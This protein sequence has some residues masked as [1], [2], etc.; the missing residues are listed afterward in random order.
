MFNPV[1][2]GWINYYASFYKSALYPTL[3]HVDQVLARWAERKYK[4]LHGHLRRARHWLARV[5]APDPG[6]SLTGSSC[7]RGLDNGSCVSRE[8]HAQFCERVGVRLPRATLLVMLF[9]YKDDAERVLEVLGKRLG[10][11]G[12]GCPHPDKT[13]MVDFRYRPFP[14]HDREEATLATTFN[15]LGFTHVWGRSRK[16]KLVVRQVTAKDRFARTLKAIDQQCRRMRHWM[17]REPHQRLCQ[18]LRGHY[19]YLASVITACGWTPCAIRPNG[20]G[21]SG[22]LA[23][24]MRA[25]CPGRGSSG[26]W[27]TFPYPAP[28]CPSLR[29]SVSESVQRRTGCSNWARPGL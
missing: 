3:R 15:F 24:R 18:M 28:A 8:V 16:G 21:A 25:L 7:S 1:V 19:A 12:L 9:A 13:R 2:P 23:G 11:Y 14:Q 29:C 5:R 10:K 6:C 26:Y 4:K 17:L 20:A 22:Y 27:N